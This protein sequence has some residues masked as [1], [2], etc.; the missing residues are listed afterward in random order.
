MNSGYVHGAGSRA[1]ALATVALLAA[2]AGFAQPD[3]PQ[4]LAISHVAQLERAEPSLR[5]YLDVETDGGQF[6]EDIDVGALS[7]TL[8]QNALRLGSSKPFTSSGEGVAFIFLVDVSASLS[9]ERFDEIRSAIDSWISNL[10]LNDRAAILAFGEQSELVVDL[11]RDID[12]LRAGLQSLAPTDRLTL[13]HRGLADALTL[14]QRQDENLPSRRVIVLL[15]DGRDEG[16]GLAL[17]DVLERLRN[18]PMPIYAIGHSQFG[19]PQR[20]R[21]LNVLRRLASNSGGAFFESDQ[22]AFAESYAWISR[23]IDRV[24]IVDAVC[25]DCAPD[26]RSYRLQLRLQKDG[27]V[28]TEGTEVRLLPMATAAADVAPSPNSSAPA[29]ETEAPSA[30]TSPPGLLRFWPLLLGVFLLAG[31]L[32]LM[33]RRRPPVVEEEIELTPPAAPPAPVEPSPP[34]VAP[35]DSSGEGALAGAGSRLRGKSIDSG[36]LAPTPDALPKVKLRPRTEIDSEAGELDPERPLRRRVVR[37]VVV[38]GQNKGR[39]Y[40]T[41]LRAR[42]VVGTRST[43]DCVLAGEENIGKEQFELL[44]RD[45]Q[46]YVQNLDEHRPTLI[47]GLAMKSRQPVNSGDLVGT[48]DTIL[49]VMLDG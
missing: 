46:V 38:R 33:L 12:A 24:L 44:Q 41:V 3:P 4:R 16:S 11:T 26:G 49:R 14:S 30:Q 36:R 47:N 39:E 18:Q 9:P 40:R 10:A 19:E 5:L 27:R 45:D 42:A 37:L 1:Q 6:L 13:L 2:S 25:P 43:C 29:L 8:G 17:E 34:P 32:A 22:T 21:D 15:S 28:L 23:A 7:G 31:A 20:S 35:A 48:Q